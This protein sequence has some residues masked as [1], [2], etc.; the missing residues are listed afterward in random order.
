M[1][2]RKERKTHKRLVRNNYIELPKFTFEDKITLAKVT[3]V[4]DGDTVTVVFWHGKE[5][6]KYSLRLYGYNCPEMRPSKKLLN[7]ETH[8]KAAKKCRDILQKLLA[9][10]NNMVWIKY[11]EE[12]KYGR[13]MGYIYM[14]PEAKDSNTYKFKFEGN[15]LCANSLMIEQG[16]GKLYKGGKKSIFAQEELDKIIQDCDKLMEEWN[17]TNN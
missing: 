11:T 17:N 3:D 16:F 12:E 5:F 14:P 1:S 2:G 10:Y 13:L 6:V 9:R 7:R 15:L 8:K 4:Y